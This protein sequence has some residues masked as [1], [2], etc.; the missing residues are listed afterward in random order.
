[1]RL[2]GDR[3]VRGRLRSFD[4]YLNIVLDNAE[5]IRS[6]GT[7]RKLGTIVIRGENVVLISPAE[8]K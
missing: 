4:I 6:D 8:V 2:R 5:E 1:V 3:D 7:T